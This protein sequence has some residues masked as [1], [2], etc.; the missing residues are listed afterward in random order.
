M[1]YISNKLSAELIA[2]ELSKLSKARDEWEN[3]AFKA[4]NEQLYG[5]LEKAFFLLEQASGRP[6]VIKQINRLLDERKL[7]YNN[8]TSLATKVARIVFNGDDKRITGYARVLRIALSEKKSSETFAAFIK[9][10]GGIEE[11]RKQQAAGM[12]SK[13]EQA[14]KHIEIAEQFYVSSE[15]LVQQIECS[16][17]ELHPDAEAQNRFVVA[18]ARKNAD[19]TL[20][21][22][23]GCNKA[24]VVKMVLV[25]GGKAADDK[26]K[27]RAQETLK[28]E[29]RSKVNALARSVSDSKHAA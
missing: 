2:F 29:Q 8:G 20:S 22:V 13:A 11:V 26:L 14:K 28:E 15:A 21:I 18:L 6:S 7:V 27:R 12:I 1:T 25:E 16:A 19:G 23:Y 4:S 24:S 9:R 3:G 10:K 17:P 5:L